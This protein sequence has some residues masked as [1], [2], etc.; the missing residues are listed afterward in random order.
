M[1]TSA[2]SHDK[3]RNLLSIHQDVILSAGFRLVYR[4]IG[5]TT[6][7]IAALQALLWLL[8]ASAIRTASGRAVYTR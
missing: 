3:H 2:H 7:C 6:P 1:T 8:A 4:R 5:M